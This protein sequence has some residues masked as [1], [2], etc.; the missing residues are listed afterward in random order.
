MHTFH[1]VSSQLCDTASSFQ[2]WTMILQ[3]GAPETTRCR[4]VR[5][6]LKCDCERR[7]GS[8]GV[9]RDARHGARAPWSL[10]MHA[11]F[12]DLTPDGFQLWMTLSPRTSE[13]M[14]HAP[15]PPWSKIL[16]TPLLTRYNQT[17]IVQQHFSKR[18][19]TRRYCYITSSTGRST[20]MAS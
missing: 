4:G 11:N 15:V 1:L 16:A 7:L 9:A 17:C 2:V 19:S 13:P 8:S 18:L 10:R 3:V 12:A 14:R 20:K 5:L 6:V